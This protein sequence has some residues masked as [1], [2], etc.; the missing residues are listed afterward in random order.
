MYSNHVILLC[1]IFIIPFWNFHVALQ[2]KQ[3]AFRETHLITQVWRQFQ[4]MLFPPHSRNKPQADSGAV[5]QASRAA[6][7]ASRKPRPQAVS[8]C[9]PCP[10]L[11]ELWMTALFCSW[12]DTQK[13][14]DFH[15]EDLPRFIH[16]FSNVNTHTHTQLE[17]NSFISNA[18][19][20][21][22]FTMKKC[23]RALAEAVT[24]FQSEALVSAFSLLVASGLG[25]VTELFKLFPHL[26]R[27]YQD[28]LW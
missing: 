1:K 13:A 3:L 24:D 12:E 15:Q 26:E 16:W 7:P 28:C 8:F 18:D 25:H 9:W 21:P 5:P 17:I 2:K 22:T 10:R 23:Q 20:A 4:H 19:W 14:K 27:G 11:T 6:R